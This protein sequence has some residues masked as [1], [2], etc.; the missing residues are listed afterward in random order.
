MNRKSQKPA[1]ELQRADKQETREERLDRIRARVKI[2]FYTR[3]DVMRDVADALLYDPSAFENL[4]Y[5]RFQIE[6][7][8]PSRRSSYP[9]DR[10][11]FFCSLDN[12]LQG[13]YH[14]NAKCKNGK[15]KSSEV[16]GQGRRKLKIESEDRGLERGSKD[17]RKS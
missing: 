3:A 9:L 11:A 7:S 16:G 14:E 15:C 13:I 5:A 8:S 1:S 12:P 4:P 17:I 6:A 2:G 10:M